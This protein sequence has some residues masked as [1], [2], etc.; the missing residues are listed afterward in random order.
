MKT[1]KSLFVAAGLLRVYLCLSV[2]ICGFVRWV[3]PGI[4]SGRWRR[5]AARWNSR[6]GGAYLVRRN[7]FEEV[8][9]RAQ[10]E[11]ALAVLRL[12]R[13]GQ[14]QGPERRLGKLRANPLE[15]LGAVHLRHLQVDKHLIGQ[16]VSRRVVKAAPICQIIYRVFA[17]SG[18]VEGNFQT[19]FVQGAT[20]AKGVVRRIFYTQ[21]RQ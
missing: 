2:F 5:H 3:A 21:Y 18:H 1:A 14:R 4:A 9:M 13:R 10:V 17:V 7:R 11:R 6:D 16:D 8:A 15:Q 12:I 20:E 19:G